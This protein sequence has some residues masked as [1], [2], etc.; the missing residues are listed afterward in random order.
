MI[1]VPF[2]AASLGEGNV[3]YEIGTETQMIHLYSDVLT[4]LFI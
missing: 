1:Y 4:Q 3:K 2:K